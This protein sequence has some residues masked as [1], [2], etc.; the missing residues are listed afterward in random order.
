MTE[1]FQPVVDIDE[2]YATKKDNKDRMPM[3][4]E[5]EI[6]A[7][8]VNPNM[9]QLAN[10]LSSKNKHVRRKALRALRKELKKGA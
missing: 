7:G 2:I 3:T 6:L 4:L 1:Q 10:A 9:R 8:I 5:D